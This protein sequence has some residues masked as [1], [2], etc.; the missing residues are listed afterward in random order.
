VR[1]VLAKRYEFLVVEKEMVADLT[2]AFRTCRTCLEWAASQESVKCECVATEF[3]AADNCL[4]R[5]LTF[6]LSS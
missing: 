3:F 1:R 5:S 2:D 6:F 4:L